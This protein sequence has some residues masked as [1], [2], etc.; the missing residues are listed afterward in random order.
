MSPPDRTVVAGLIPGAPGERSGLAVGDVLVRVDEEPVT[1]RLQL[2]EAIWRRK[3]GESIELRVMREGH[4]ATV[5]VT[6]GDAEEFFA[7]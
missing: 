3:P 6:S 5:T 7:I 1:G 2:Y 4:M